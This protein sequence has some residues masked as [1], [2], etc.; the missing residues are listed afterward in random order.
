MTCPFGSFYRALGF[1][2]FQ[3]MIDN[4]QRLADARALAQ[5]HKELLTAAGFEE[6]A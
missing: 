5:S 4:V 6:F 1:A 2:Y 3:S